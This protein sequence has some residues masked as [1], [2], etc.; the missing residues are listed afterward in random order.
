MRS[1]NEKCKHKVPFLPAGSSG[2]TNGGHALDIRAE[3]TRSVD[4][5]DSLLAEY[6]ALT[7]TERDKGNYFEGVTA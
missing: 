7:P 1:G 2:S 5:F 3:T 4:A 6:R